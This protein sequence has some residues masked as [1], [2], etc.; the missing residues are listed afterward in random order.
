MGTLQE[1]P[2]SFALAAGVA[3]LTLILLRRSWRY[4]RRR[5]RRDRRANGSAPTRSV[6]DAFSGSDRDPLVDAPPEVLRWH[7]ALHE[8]AR[9]LQAELETKMVIVDQL[10]VQARREADRLERILAQCDARSS[11]AV[12]IESSVIPRRRSGL[13][14]GEP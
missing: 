7:V 9:D 13:Q 5:R 8:T 4:E 1:A 11:A 14:G 10:I 6:G 2:S 3:L 12:P